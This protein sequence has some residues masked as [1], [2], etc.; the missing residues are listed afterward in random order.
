[1]P[2]LNFAELIFLL[3]NPQRA[4]HTATEYRSGFAYYTLI[5]SGCQWP[6]SHHYKIIIFQYNIG[7][8]G[9]EERACLLIQPVKRRR[10]H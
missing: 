9:H 10:P 7:I 2:N 4:A 3:R 8:Y 6:G 1:M 5:H